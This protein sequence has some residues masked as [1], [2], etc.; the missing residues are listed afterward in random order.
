MKYRSIHFVGIGGSGMSPLAKIMLESGCR[1]SGSDMKYSDKIKKLAASGAEV[2]VGHDAGNLPPDLDLVVVSSAVNH[3]NPEILEAKSRDIP[4]LTRAQFLGD[5]MKDYTTVGVSGAHGKTTTTAM[6]G[7]IFYENGLDPTIAIGGELPVLGGSG[8][9]GKGRYFIAEADEA[10]G[11]FLQFYPAIAV[12]TNIDDDHLDYYGNLNS[13]INAFREYLD[14]LPANGLAVLCAD[15]PH[16]RKIIPDMSK[17]IITYS[18]NEQAD[19]Q[20]VNIE[21]KNFGSRFDVCSHGQ[22]IG[23]LEL[24]IPGLHNISNALAAAVVSLEAGLS[25]PCITKSL[26]HY[27]GAHRRFEKIGEAEGVT[28]IDDYAHHPTEIKAT[29]EA[30]RKG[31]PGRVISVFQP[32]RYTRTKFLRYEF[33]RSFST[34]DLII[35]TDIYFQGTGETPL[36]GI[37]G[38]ILAKEVESYEK[39]PVYF[40][41]ELTDVLLFLEQIVKPGDLVVTMGAGNIYTVAYQL[42]QNLCRKKDVHPG[43]VKIVGLDH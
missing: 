17:R 16:I 22:N 24:N 30:A 18:L 7:L 41:S 40:R 34:A 12:V 2:F 36:P 31:W 25:M 10:Y 42:Y 32:Q 15:N 39:R 28:I 6:I 26:F 14:H 8:R 19:Y 1:I 20:A 11:S 9:L 13:I 35:L 38:E 33:A 21:L 5:L 37:S 23:T 29:L 3:D 4:I 27:R 43:S